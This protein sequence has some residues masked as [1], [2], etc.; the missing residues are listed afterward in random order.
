[1]ILQ[2]I[3]MVAT[4]MIANNSVINRSWRRLPHF[5]CVE[6]KHVVALAEPFVICMTKTLTIKR[7]GVSKTNLYQDESFSKLFERLVDNQKSPPK[8]FKATQRVK[9]SHLEKVKQDSQL[10]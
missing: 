6:T 9:L 2:A 3:Q 10:K 7:L 5:I 4:L 8:N 1:L